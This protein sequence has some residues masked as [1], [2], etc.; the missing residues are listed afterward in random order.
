MKRRLHINWTLDRY[1][2]SISVHHTHNRRWDNTTKE[3][4]PIV[5][6]Y[7]SSEKGDQSIDCIS[8]KGTRNHLSEKGARKR[9]TFPRSPVRG[10]CRR[11]RFPKALP[12]TPMVLA[13][14]PI[15]HHVVARTFPSAML[16]PHQG[17]QPLAKTCY[18]NVSARC[19]LITTNRSNLTM[20][21][22]MHYIWE[23][24]HALK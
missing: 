19:R 20:N 14:D 5:S 7:G 21:I 16:S 23:R 1:E 4:G 22:W 17:N 18:L 3:L 11:L 9:P 15:P 24:K 8:T 6:R 10:A 13:I 12:Q 2:W